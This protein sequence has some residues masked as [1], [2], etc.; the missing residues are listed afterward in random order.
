MSKAMRTTRAKPLKP[1]PTVVLVH[2]AWLDGSS[3]SEVIARLQ[4]AE[5]DAT[6]V[7]IPLTSLDDDVACVTRAIARAEGSVLLVGHSWGGTVITQAG[8]LDRVAGLVYVCGFAPAL[9]EST[10]TVQGGYEPAAYLS[11]LRLDRAGFLTMPRE[12]FQDSLAHDLT[13]VHIDVLAAAQSPILAAA[14]EEPVNVAA[15]RTKPSWYLVAENDRIVDPRLQHAM[16]SRIG[17]H[18][19]TVATSH[20]PML[21]KPKETTALILLAAAG[22]G[23]L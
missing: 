19:A 13:R 7:Q 3:W 14:L 12:V 2:G 18:V 9:A 15:W 22:T 16:A 6:A 10:S 17:A 11:R 21:S 23:E 4:E 5:L 8:L 1:G 20:V